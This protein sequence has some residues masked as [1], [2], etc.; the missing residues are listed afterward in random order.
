MHDPAENSLFNAPETL[1]ACPRR[2]E[3]KDL[4]GK[5]GMGMV[6]R[7]FDRE[8]QR[9]IA[10]KLLWTDGQ[11]DDNMRERFMREAKAM[12]VLNHPNI[13]QL[14]TSGLNDNGYPYHVMEYL[15]GES[16]QAELSR[17][18]LTAER[19]CELFTQITA[20]L[21]HAHNQGIAHRDLKPS[22]IMI[23]NDGQS[24]VCKII[25][26]GI[27][28]IEL[29]PELAAKTITRADAFLGSPLYMSPEQC[30]GVRGNFRSDIYMLGC[31]MYECIAGN[32]PFSGDSGMEIM[33]KHMSEQPPAL[34]IKSNSSQSKR[35]AA[36]V[37][38]C[39][40][41][42]PT[43]R[44]ESISAVAAEL[45]EIFSSNTEKLDLFG[46][47]LSSRKRANPIVVGGFVFILLSA[48][49]TLGLIYFHK[50]P[51]PNAVIIPEQ[52]KIQ[53][54]IAAAKLKLETSKKTTFQEKLKLLF[55]LGR[56]QLK[57]TSSQDLRD[58]ES[59]F[60]QALEL[61]KANGSP[62]DR[63]AA[64][65]T[66]R[67]KARWKQENI[68]AADSD[69]D[70]AL[71]VIEGTEDPEKQELMYDYLNE[72]ILMRIHQRKLA[73][74]YS[75]LGQ[76]AANWS[77]YH[78]KSNLIQMID[79]STQHLD[80]SGD[81]RRLMVR[82]C[83]AELEKIKPRNEDEAVEMV[84]LSTIYGAAF[85][86]KRW[87]HPPAAAKNALKFAEYILNTYVNDAKQKAKLDLE[88]NALR[89]VLANK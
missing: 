83:E 38:S 2:Y 68:S 55:N 70:E 46:Q 37:S 27:A 44:P 24:R 6:F 45:S 85:A 21:E 61:C 10:L 36:L 84:R 82:N 30:R 63:I 57:S 58:A 69:F 48:V 4:I 59:T 19:F 7:A 79:S 52:Q 73:E 11:C 72:K 14:F 22:N 51:E 39:M 66:L 40:Q 33:Y 64:C 62:A 67:G 54:K 25:D 34:A 20:G 23:C 65:F 42:D 77:T 89:Q 18:P 26:F 49:A 16:L 1:A 28:R 29:N 35:L 12:S 87:L 80:K 13:V 56:S 74:A 43:A 5:G 3:I 31:I 50:P 32:T 81:E 75:L 71:K 17:G 78:E 76:S 8:L 60:N 41:K 15:E 86:N 47:S 88:L 9:D 53:E